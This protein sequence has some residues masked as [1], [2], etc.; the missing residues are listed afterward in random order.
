[1]RD[2]LLRPQQV[3]DMFGVSRATIWN[4]LKTKP[5]FPKPKKLSP[6]ITTWKES[7]LQAYMDN[8]AFVA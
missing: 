1:M 8:H 2:N 7:E 4:W 3:A 6:K 5:L